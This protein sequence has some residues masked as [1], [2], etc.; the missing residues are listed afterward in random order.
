MLQFYGEVVAA[1]ENAVRDES[2]EG[3][4]LYRILK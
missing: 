2:V 3:M 1:L 4:L